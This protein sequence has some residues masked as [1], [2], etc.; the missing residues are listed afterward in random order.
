MW[1]IAV[2]AYTNLELLEAD[3]LAIW[4]S[5]SKIPINISLTSTGNSIEAL[6]KGDKRLIPF[7]E[8]CKTKVLIKN[9]IEGRSKLIYC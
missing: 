2:W 6:S 1:D 3:L 7:V 5:P 9:I 4:P 8:R